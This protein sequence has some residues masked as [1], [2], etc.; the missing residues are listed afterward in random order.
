MGNVE[1]VVTMDARR[2][3]RNLVHRENSHCPAIRSNMVQDLPYLKKDCLKNNGELREETNRGICRR[4]NKIYLIFSLVHLDKSF[5]NRRKNS[6]TN[7]EVLAGI[8]VDVLK[9]NS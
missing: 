8:S 1:D 4:Y 3:N 6:E 2:K 5:E 9:R 7:A